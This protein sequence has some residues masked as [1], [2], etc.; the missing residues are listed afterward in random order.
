M[1]NRKPREEAARVVTTSN[2]IRIETPKSNRQRKPK[3]T[4]LVQPDD[5]VRD[6]IGGFVSFLR[7]H[8]VVGLAIGFVIGAQAQAVVKQLISSFIEPA[9]ALLFGGQKLSVLTSTVSFN[10]RSQS[11]SWGAMVYVLINFLFVLGAI[12]FIIKVFKLDKLDKPK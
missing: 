1:A 12:Y 5:L 7:E 2:T 6:Q 11:F 10:G 8:A 9:F 3:V 4:V